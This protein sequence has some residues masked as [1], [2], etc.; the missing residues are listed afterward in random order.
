ML[1]FIDH[2]RMLFLVLLM[3]HE[4]NCPL[5]THAMEWWIW[6]PPL[7]AASV[8]QKRAQG[9]EVDTFHPFHW[10]DR[11]EFVSSGATR[12]RRGRALAA[13]GA[14]CG[15]AGGRVSRVRLGDATSVS[16]ASKTLVPVQTPV[17]KIGSSQDAPLQRACAF[18]RADNL[19]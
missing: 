5:S 10:G 15:E 18:V 16:C 6:E 8:R 13:A 12:A 3:L 11:D 9:M 4:L 1:F 7:N 17:I 19:T 14:I 2:V